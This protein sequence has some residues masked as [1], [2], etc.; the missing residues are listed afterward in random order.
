[1]P[2]TDKKPFCAR[3]VFRNNAF[4]TVSLFRRKLFLPLIMFFS[5]TSK[6]ARSYIK[7][8]GK[9][10]TLPRERFVKRTL[11]FAFVSSLHLHFL[12]DHKRSCHVQIS[13]RRLWWNVY[14]YG[15]KQ[16]L[17]KPLLANICCEKNKFMVLFRDLCF[18]PSQTSRLLGKVII[19]NLLP[20]KEALGFRV[21]SGKPV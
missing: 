20:G 8:A 14:V 13:T 11:Q 2:Y 3:G 15:L 1:M 12:S 21:Y 4:E 5:M 7:T 18:E 9:K 10:R 6:A 16:L 17:S 19:Y